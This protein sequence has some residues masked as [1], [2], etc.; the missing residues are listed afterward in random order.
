MWSSSWHTGG[1]FAAG[2]TT[3]ILNLEKDVTNGVMQA[4][5]AP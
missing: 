2:V 1:K 4:G 5:S 3:I